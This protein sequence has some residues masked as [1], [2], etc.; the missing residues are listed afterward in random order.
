LA[1]PP[2][3]LI[4]AAGL[5][6][7]YGGFKQIDELGKF[8]ETILDYSV[9]DAYRAGIRKVVFVIREN[10]ELE[11]KKAVIEKLPSDLEA[12]YVFQEL[13]DIPSGLKYSKKRE[14]PW[15]T[16]HAV[17]TAS[18]EIDE[19][20]IVINA[21][22][23]YGANS[24]RS[25]VDFSLGLKKSHY[26][27]I[28]YKLNRTLSDFG[29]VSRGICE[30]DESGYLQSVVERTHIKKENGKIIF[31]DEDENIHFLTGDEIVSMNMF[32]FGQD[33]FEHLEKYFKEF[34]EKNFDNLKAEFYLPFV[35]NRLI[36]EKKVKVKVLPTS[37]N[38]FGLTYKEDKKAA[39]E[40]VNRLIQE[41]KYP[42]KLWK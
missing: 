19:P 15:G 2:T 42:G 38:W 34:I 26:A 14:K 25:A 1:N 39:K 30:V 5:G 13:S 6:A 32:L 12:K 8:G 33:F 23:F 35:V 29:F 11:F 4:L 3:L 24:Y 7:R 37:E 9:Y 17:L 20:F 27:L 41:K 16:G 18:S 21:D 40:K 36:S 31:E 22:D 10:F 28:G